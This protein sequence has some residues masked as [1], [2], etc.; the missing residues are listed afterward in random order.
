MK[1]LTSLLSISCFLVTLCAGKPAPTDPSGGKGTQSTPPWNYPGLSIKN[2]FSP[3]IQTNTYSLFPDLANTPMK[4]GPLPDKVNIP[5]KTLS[6]GYYVIFR[7]LL[8]PQSEEVKDF[9]GWALIAANYGS[10]GLTPETSGWFV[11]QA[12]LDNGVWS[13][14]GWKI[15]GPPMRALDASVQSYLP[16]LCIPK[17]RLMNLLNTMVRALSTLSLPNDSAKGKKMWVDS[18]VEYLTYV[19]K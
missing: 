8:A 1:P 15:E 18:A 2:G 11:Y 3:D 17:E 13:V 19:P 5:D 14:G 12:H 9:H 16:I 6:L 4:P 7:V 10:M